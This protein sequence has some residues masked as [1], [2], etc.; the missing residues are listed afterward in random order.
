MVQNFVDLVDLQK[1]CKTENE[2]VSFLVFCFFFGR[3][4]RRTPEKTK[5][6]A[7]ERKNGDDELRNG[8]RRNSLD[9]GDV[10]RAVVCDYVGPFFLFRD[11]RLFPF[12]SNMNKLQR[13]GT[14]IQKI[15]NNQKHDRP[16]CG[17]A[18][19]GTREHQKQARE[20]KTRRG[21]HPSGARFCT[22]GIQ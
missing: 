7:N 10:L 2:Y 21:A 11:A 12:L 8:Q 20:R 14:S 1:S 18:P 15:K 19:K 9:E 6:N 5:K 17:L 3:S 16:E 4:G 13:R 22:F